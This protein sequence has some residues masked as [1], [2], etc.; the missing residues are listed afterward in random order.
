MTPRRA[1]YDKALA[2]LGIT[3]IMDVTAEQTGN[4]P[5]AG[6]GKNGKP[7]FW[8]SD[9]EKVSEPIHVAFAA[10]DRKTVDLFYKAA[11]AA[12][13]KDNG[14]PGYPRDLSSE[15]LRRLRA[16][17]RRQQYRSRVPRAGVKT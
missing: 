13:G 11:I 6:F 7:F 8:F 2:P 14:A 4:Y 10:P 3:L 5:A 12:G 9:E 15:L 1:F 17:S 16:R